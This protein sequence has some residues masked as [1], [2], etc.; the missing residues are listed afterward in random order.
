MRNEVAIEFVDDIRAKGYPIRYFYPVDILK[1]KPETKSKL[2]ETV[3]KHT[4]DTDVAATVEKWARSAKVGES[5]IDKYLT[6]EVERL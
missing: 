5:Y 2:Y 6:A 1:T 4:G 3:L